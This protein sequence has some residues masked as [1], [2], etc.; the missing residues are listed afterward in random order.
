MTNQPERHKDS[1]TR[2][3]K[4]QEGPRR[5]NSDN[6]AS[7]QVPSQFPPSTTRSLAGLLKHLQSSSKRLLTGKGKTGSQKRHK[8]RLIYR[9]VTRNLVARYLYGQT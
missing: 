7:N 1:Q 4:M 3:E 8:D 2:K 5:A 9:T 6:T